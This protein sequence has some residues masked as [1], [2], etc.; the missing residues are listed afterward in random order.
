MSCSGLELLK[1]SEGFRGSVYADVAGFRTI[2]FGHRLSAGET[3][4]DSISLAQG[5]AILSRDIAIAE[6]AVCR[7][8]K[9]PLTQGQFDALVDFVFNLGAGRLASSTLLSYLNSGKYDDA[10]WQLLAWDHAGSKEIASLK[11]RREAEFHLW[12]PQCTIH[13]V[14]A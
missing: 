6:A 5:E 12:N 9:R 1:K 8:V 11:S 3:Y 10:A 2:G 7:L 14:A 13:G 4:P